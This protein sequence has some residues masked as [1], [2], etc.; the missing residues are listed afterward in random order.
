MKTSLALDIFRE[1]QKSNLRPTTVIGYRY[2]LDN[3]EV[4]FGDKDFR[5]IRSEEFF[6]QPQ[7]RASRDHI[8]GSTEASEPEDDAGLSRKDQRSRSHSLDGHSPRQT[9]QSA[10]STL[11]LS[12]EAQIHLQING[13]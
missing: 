11:G 5:S 3:F 8:Q 7:R 1:Y 10:L 2:L 6:R 12:T 13:Q 4:L 9:I